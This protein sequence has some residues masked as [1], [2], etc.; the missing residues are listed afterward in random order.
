MKRITEINEENEVC[1]LLLTNR[2]RM[3]L[4][5]SL[6]HTLDLADLST[7]ISGGIGMI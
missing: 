5:S 2:S 4:S 3:R 7:T 1:W 6:G